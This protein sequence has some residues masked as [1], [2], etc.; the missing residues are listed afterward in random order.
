M[1]NRYLEIFGKSLIK[2]KDLE[3]ALK[4]LDELTHEE[5]R[6]VIAELR[7][8]AYAISKNVRGVSGQMTAIGDG[9]A[10]I[11][12]QRWLSIPDPSMNHNT[13]QKSRHSGTAA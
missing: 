5:V 12:V 4:K 3:D 7:R 9:V 13:V 1:T 10:A 2:T 6:M 11:D 8:T